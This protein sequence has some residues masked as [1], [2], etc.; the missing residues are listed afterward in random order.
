MRKIF[1]IA[2]QFQFNSKMN[3]NNGKIILFGF[4]SVERK[5]SKTKKSLPDSQ[6]FTGLSGGVVYSFAGNPLITNEILIKE[7]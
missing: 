7:S 3:T 1:I 6:L 5:T 4:R 2:R